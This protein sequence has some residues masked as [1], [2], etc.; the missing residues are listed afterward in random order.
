MHSDGTGAVQELVVAS[1]AE[2]LPPDELLQEAASLDA[3]LLDLVSN[4]RD[5]DEV[6]QDLLLP[7]AHQC[8]G[9]QTEALAGNSEAALQERSIVLPATAGAF[10]P[11]DAA[12]TESLLSLPSEGVELP[13]KGA[14]SMGASSRPDA[15]MPPERQRRPKCSKSRRKPP[16][17]R[18]NVL[19]DSSILQCAAADGWSQPKPIT[20]R[21]IVS[22]WTLHGHEV[23][24]VRR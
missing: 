24:T 18:S 20:V 4:S 6:S 3:A 22:E 1:I 14:I 12:G 2:A 17:D 15:D 8:L 5:P 23:V 9:E 13:S 10:L 19:P 11:P 7:P 21:D 16:V